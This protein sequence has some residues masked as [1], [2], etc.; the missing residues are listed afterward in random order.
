MGSLALGQDASGLGLS[1]ANVAIG[2]GADT[3]DDA[4]F[5]TIVGFLAGTNLTAG[6][7]DIYIGDEVG[8]TAPA[9]E[10]FTI[11]IGDLSN[12]FGGS[13]QCF[14]GGISPNVQDSDGITKFVVTID[15]TTDHLGIQTSGPNGPG[16]APAVPA[17]RQHTAPQPRSAPQ[18]RARPQGP[19]R[20]AMV[21]DKVENLEATVAQQQKQIEALQSAAV[22]AAVAGA[23][24]A[25]QQKQIETLTGQLREQAAQIQQVSAAVEMMKPAPRVVENR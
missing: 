7:D 20:Q 17:P 21:N 1:S 14:V 5:N 10:T 24:V 8:T 3:F 18:P 6:F 13:G 2:F 25:Q 4:A 22:K 15:V 12:G 9:G 11:R 23:T 19:Q 16:K